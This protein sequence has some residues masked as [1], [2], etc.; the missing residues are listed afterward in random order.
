[1]KGPYTSLKASSLGKIMT[2]KEE[3]SSQK[4]LNAEHRQAIRQLIEEA[5]SGIRSRGHETD[6]AY[7]D[8]RSSL[9]GELPHTGAAASGR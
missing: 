3:I 1:M 9:Q 2:M 5:G 8:N 6:P 7:M 4:E